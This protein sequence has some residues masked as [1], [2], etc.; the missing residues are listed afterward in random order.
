MT[1][2][3]AQ[4]RFLLLAAILFVGNYAMADKQ[5]PEVV[6]ALAEKK[7]A[8]PLP[9]AFNEITTAWNDAA[10]AAQLD[11]AAEESK[12]RSYLQQFK[13]GSQKI[14]LSILVIEQKDAQPLVK[15][16]A[17]PGNAPI[18]AILTALGRGGV[19]GDKSYHLLVAL[20]GKE[21][22]ACQLAHAELQPILDKA[23]QELAA[24]AN[25]AKEKA[26][27]RPESTVPETTPE[28]AFQRMQQAQKTYPGNSP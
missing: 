28:A 18:T 19:Q 24:E 8:K 12:L 21:L 17:T 7:I 23:S 20:E 13:A 25:A 5:A 11:P 3:T 9:D 2:L 22:T 26:A 1:T 10:L 4:I 27:T 6:G 15:I 14:L 16:A